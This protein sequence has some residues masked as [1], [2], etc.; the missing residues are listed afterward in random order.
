MNEFSSTH[1]YMW[2]MIPNIHLGSSLFWYPVIV[3]INPT[4]K[5]VH[6]DASRTSGCALL[7]S[8]PA[9]CDV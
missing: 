8:Q 2:R 1:A 7:L 3:E 4:S 6:S 9:D 5:S